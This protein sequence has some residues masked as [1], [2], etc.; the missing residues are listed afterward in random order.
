[1]VTWCLKLQTAQIGDV[2][3]GAK[4]NLSLAAPARVL[5]GRGGKLRE[6]LD[7]WEL[8]LKSL[9]QAAC[10]QVNSMI[11]ELHMW[12]SWYSEMAEFDRKKM[13]E[14]LARA[15]KALRAAFVSLDS[16]E[17][18]VATADGAKFAGFVNAKAPG[19]RGDHLSQGD[20]HKLM[21]DEQVNILKSQPPI[22]LTTWIDDS[23]DF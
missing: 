23:A 21:N 16:G 20:V 4:E 15:D 11:Q 6:H 8:E 14:L 18:V 9:Y 1:V 13:C 10:I 17:S 12:P 5:E 19:L 2:D 3:D 7:V 22:K